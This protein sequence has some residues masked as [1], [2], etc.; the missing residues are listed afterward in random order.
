MTCI[1]IV[2]GP[3]K[4]IAT[5]A[6]WF[7]SYVN[8]TP[9]FTLLPLIVTIINVILNVCFVIW[10]LKKYIR[11]V[12]YVDKVGSKEIVFYDYFDDL[13]KA[14]SERHK[15]S[16][17]TIML[18]SFLHFHFSKLLYSRFYCRDMFEARFEFSKVFRKSMMIFCIV[19]LIFVDVL[20]IAIDI[21][22][23]TQIASNN[24]L[25]ITMIDT[26]LLSILSIILCG[27]EI[28]RM[29]DILKYTELTKR[30]RLVIH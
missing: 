1:L 26:L 16:F 5:V 11:Q 6:Q 9:I 2:L 21:T 20:M 7:L 17:W 15:I 10:F 23:L 24:Q 13:L 22:G 18:L 28:Y 12:K 8:K 27:L 3:V 30:E 29:T 25:F 14:H 19:Y 4:S